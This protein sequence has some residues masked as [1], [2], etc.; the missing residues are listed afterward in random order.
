MSFRPPSAE[1]GEMVCP[2]CYMLVEPDAKGNCPECGGIV[3]VSADEPT[4]AAPSVP[5]APGVS[6]VPG[7]P[8]PPRVP[9]VPPVS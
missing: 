5:T 1:A 3:R 4:P 8:K 2:H 9:P 6:R 7:A